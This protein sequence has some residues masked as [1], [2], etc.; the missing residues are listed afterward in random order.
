MDRSPET[1]AA[2]C[3]MAPEPAD[4]PPWPDDAPEVGAGCWDGMPEKVYRRHTAVSHSDIRHWLK[5][6]KLGRAG[7]IGSAVHALVLEGRAAL[8]A[9]FLSVDEDFDMRTTAGKER[10]AELLGDSGK[11][12]LRRKE[13]AEV[14]LLFNE[15]GS[16][17]GARVILGKP[18]GNEVSVVSAFDGFDQTYKARIDMVRG[19]SLW[20]LKTTSCV[21]EDDWVDSEVKFGY[22][23]QAEWYSSLYAALTG[24]HLPFRFLCVSKQAPH[25]VWARAVPNELMALGRKWREDML[26]LY[27]RYVPKEMRSGAKRKRSGV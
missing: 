7:I 24:E 6:R 14:E 1:L 10:G 12:L 25:N 17:K 21:N 5:P 26:T 9:Q 13:R 8:D 22:I 18:G 11:V 3:P 19:T 20:D 16:S 27:E 15:L 23:H 2:L 4:T